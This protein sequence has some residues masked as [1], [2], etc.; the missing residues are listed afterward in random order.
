M[1]AARFLRANG[2]LRDIAAA[3]LHCNPSHSYVV[4]G[5]S[6]ADEMHRDAHAFY[7]YYY[8]QVLYRTTRGTFLLPVG[9]PGVPPK[10]LRG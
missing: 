9:Y 10:R 2:G 1:A 3:L 5:E 6:Y 4:A 8:R 7:V